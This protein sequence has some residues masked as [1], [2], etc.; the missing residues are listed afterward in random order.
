MNDDLKY[1]FTNV[2]DWL[3]FAEAKN[4]GLLA[5]NVAATIGL[6]EVDKKLFD[7]LPS[8]YGI[9]LIAFCVSSAICIYSILPYLRWIKSH[10]KLGA[11]DFSTK[12]ADLN[13][14]FFGDISI[15]I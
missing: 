6:L 12:K 14:L 15:Q 2:N 5:L 4:A 10:V 7:P 8:T 3:K 1:I 11:S 13:V 9:L